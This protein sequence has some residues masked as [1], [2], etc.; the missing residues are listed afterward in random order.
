[1]FKKRTS[2]ILLHL[3]SLPGNHGIGDLGPGAYR[4]IDFLA[5]SGQRCW[6][7]LPTGP[8]STAFDNSPY[9]CRSV[10]A[11]N[12]LLINMELLVTEKYLSGKDME[13][14]SSF[15]EYSVDYK[16]VTAYKN[17]LLNKAFTGFMASGQSSGFE[18]FC[19]EQKS[20]LDDYALFM[21]LRELFDSMPWYQWPEAVA[22]RDADA[23]SSYRTE[24]TDK[25]FYHKFVQFLF[26][27]QWQKIYDYA[28]AKNISLI[29]DIPI[30]V[31][32][33]S[34]D[35]WSNQEL[36]KIDSETLEPLQ[37]AGVPP[38]YFSETGQRWGNPVYKWKTAD[39]KIN[40][41]LYDWWLARFRIIFSMMDMVKIDHFRGFEAFWEIPA[42]EKTAIN[43]KWVKG[44]GKSFFT[45]LK[46]QLKELPIIAEDLGIITPAVD[47]MREHLGF[48]GM[49]VLQF[50][51]ESDEKNPYLPHNFA[52]TNTIVYTGTH[53]NNT[54]LGWFLGDKLSEST[55]DR[56]RRYVN[57]Y[58]DSRIAWEFVRLA[59]SSTAALAI[60]PLQDILGFGEDCQMNRPGTREGNWRWRCA[61]RFLNDKVEQHLFDMTVF[62]NRLP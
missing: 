4:F 36:F 40:R 25:I 43:G 17:T 34:A 16:K 3:T 46:T 54:T 26:F 49:R 15:S 14:E 23:L 44:P 59:L 48:P 56:I 28:H 38:D 47:K 53:D 8:T 55:R 51:F 57:S 2:G 41:K 31:A 7:F 6:Q 58:D 39:G 9:M 11:G 13:G 61:P 20:W 50:A 10:F 27:S 42:G 30:Y 29:G 60:T 35:V 21:S 19:R 45:S 12:P 62:Y 33:D 1:M 52:E 5:A 37:V 32:L 18:L 22:R 24:L